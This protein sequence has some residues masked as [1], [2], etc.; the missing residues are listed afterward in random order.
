MSEVSALAARSDH[1]IGAA[2]ACVTSVTAASASA[3]AASGSFSIASRPKFSDCPPA[4][5]GGRSLAWPNRPNGQSSNSSSKAGT[6]TSM[7]L[8]IKPSASSAATS[9]YRR[10]ERP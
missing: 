4:S 8:D 9:K 5:L 3:I 10:G 6:V 7:A 1:A 2:W